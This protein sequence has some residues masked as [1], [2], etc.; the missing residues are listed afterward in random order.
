MPQKI[1][2]GGDHRALGGQ[3]PAPSRKR[4][5]A[6]LQAASHSSV[7]SASVLQHTPSQTPPNPSESSELSHFRVDIKDGSLNLPISCPNKQCHLTSQASRP[8]VNPLSSAA[9]RV[10]F[11][12]RPPKAISTGWGWNSGGGRRYR[13]PYR[14][15]GLATAAIRRANRR[16]AGGAALPRAIDGGAGQRESQGQAAFGDP[17]AHGPACIRSTG[18][19]ALTQSHEGRQRGN[20]A[21]RDAH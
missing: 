12:S 1:L 16:T 18:V 21:A 20:K 19:S 13:W 17:V 8:G 5:L 14:C 7:Q 11:P 4:W 3:S 15:R 10:T 2:G 9:M 6:A